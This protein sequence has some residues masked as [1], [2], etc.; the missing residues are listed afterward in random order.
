MA[1]STST[2]PVQT[3]I[4][5]LDGTSS[6]DWPNTKPTNIEKR[7]TTSYRTK[8]NRSNLSCYVHSHDIGEQDALSTAAET[9]DEQEHVRVECWSPTESD[10]VDCGGDVKSI[11]EDYWDDRTTNT[12]WQRI[13]PQ[14]VDDRRAEAQAMG[15]DMYVVAVDV[16]LRAENAIGT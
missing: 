15:A 1:T 10:A 12:T 9:K 5:L 6:S 8:T 4:D 2:D 14:S 11:L 16:L 3:V 13:R 7:W